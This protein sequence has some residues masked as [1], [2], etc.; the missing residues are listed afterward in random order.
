MLPFD[1]HNHVHMGPSPPI[2]A[3]LPSSATAEI[4]P[5]C[6]CCLSG[7]AIMSTHPRDYQTVLSL[8]KDLPSQV[9]SSSSSTSI[10]PCLG[11]HPWFLHELSLQDW[12]VDDNDNSSLPTWIQELEALLVAN[13]HAMVGEIGLDGFHFDPTTQQ[14]TSPMERQV[15][16]FRLQ[17]ELAARLDRP[18]SIHTVQCFGPLFAVL[19]QFSSSN[20]KRKKKKQSLPPKL[21]FHA[22]G[23]KAA[24]VEQILALC[25]REIG[26]VYFG[27]APIINFRSPKTLNVI[28]KVGIERLVLETDHEDAARVPTSMEQGIE[29]IAAALEMGTQQVVDQTTANAMDLY[30]LN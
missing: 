8:A 23:G 4:L 26:R 3:L 11:V 20:K 9:A 7:M 13:P 18:V 10:V 25:G 1:A 28:Q 21:Y 6:C 15:E 2:Q 12:Q 19:S 30:N 29:I 22:Y 24:T 17:L 16:A 5:T 27:F 14:L